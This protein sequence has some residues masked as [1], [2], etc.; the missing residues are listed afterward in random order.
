MYKY[1]TKALIF[2]NF[3]THLTTA[4]NAMRSEVLF[5]SVEVP[6]KLYPRIAF[7]GESYSPFFLSQRP[8]NGLLLKTRVACIIRL[9]N[10]PN[11]FPAQVKWTP[12][13]H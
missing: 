11:T 13:Y 4:T 3:M 6:I 9:L 1:T 12:V 7:A 10:I 2:L 8:T 5:V